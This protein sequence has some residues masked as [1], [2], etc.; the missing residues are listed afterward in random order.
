MKKA[1]KN[2]VIVFSIAGW[3]PAFATAATVEETVKETVTVQS[4]DVPNRIVTVKESDGTTQTLEVSDKVKNLPQ[5]KAGDRITVS[6]TKALAAEIKKPGAAPT[7]TQ[8]TETQSTAP[9]GSTPGAK[10]HQMVKTEI[11]VKSVD[12]A[13][14]TLT[15]VGPQ[16]R[17]RTITAVKPEMQELL[18][19]MKPGDKVE[20]AYTE[21]LAIDV[22]P[23][24]R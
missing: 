14:N 10:S 24:K 4:V 15:F 6:F 12:T 2:I 20:V 13:K 7:P 21:A 17:T 9:E 8:A 19:Q 3:L 23:A 16:G 18:K 11:T 5:L 22:Q 1:L